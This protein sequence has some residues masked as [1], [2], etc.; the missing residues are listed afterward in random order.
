MLSKEIIKFLECGCGMPRS[1]I[2]S[3]NKD[4]RIYH[5]LNVYG[6]EAH[7]AIEYL[8]ENCGVNMT[9]FD[10]DRCFP[11]E[12]IGDSIVTQII[13][14]S[15]PFVGHLIRRKGPWIPLTLERVEDIIRNKK[16]S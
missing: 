6:D 4:T 1:R 10:F 16:W 12:F 7:A 11:A 8:A 14:S 15:I 3:C 9:N 5:D 13:F 2:Y